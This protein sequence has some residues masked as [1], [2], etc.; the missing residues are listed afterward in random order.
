MIS[1]KKKVFTKIPCSK[2]LSGRNQKFKC[3]F[4]LKTGDLQKKKGLHPKIVMKFSVSP[5]RLP[6]YCSQTPIWAWICTP[7]RSSPK[8]VNF[9]AA[10]SLLGGAQFL[11]GGAQS[12]NAPLLWR[13]AWNRINGLFLRVPVS[14]F[15]LCRYI[16]VFF[17][18][19]LMW[20]CIWI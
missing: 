19:I 3:F 2:G 9:F 1:K 14:Y 17:L 5:Q 13:Q 10:Q 6:K 11:F 18:H 4:R 7:V 20:C 12:Q 16:P 8:P 15:R